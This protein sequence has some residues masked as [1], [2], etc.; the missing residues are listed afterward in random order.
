MLRQ[1]LLFPPFMCCV[2]PSHA[3]KSEFG[4]EM[5]AIHQKRERREKKLSSY[6]GAEKQLM[7]NAMNIIRDRVALSLPFVSVPSSADRARRTTTSLRV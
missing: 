7:I 2:W 3:L 5:T 1:V 6:E 4:N